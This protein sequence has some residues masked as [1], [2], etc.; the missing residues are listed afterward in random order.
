MNEHL[1][2]VEFKTETEHFWHYYVAHDDMNGHFKRPA[3][4]SDLP[5]LKEI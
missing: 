3:H 2:C 5:F 1:V 4:P